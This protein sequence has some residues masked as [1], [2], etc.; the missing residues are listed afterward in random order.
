MLLNIRLPLLN[1]EISW[2]LVWGVSGAHCVNN[3]LCIL[4][5]PKNQ[6]FLFF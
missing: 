5:T 3:M 2:S 4:D 6:K 1:D